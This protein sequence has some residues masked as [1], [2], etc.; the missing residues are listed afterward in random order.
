MSYYWQFYLLFRHKLQMQIV[1][2][3]KLKIPIVCV[4]I[5]SYYELVNSGILDESISFEEF[6]IIQNE[7]RNNEVKEKAKYQKN[8]IQLEHPDDIAGAIYSTLANIP[9]LVRGDI[10]I[11]NG[12]SSFGLTGHA[13]IVVGANEI[14]HITGSNSIPV[15]LIINFS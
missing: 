6:E 15:S 12:T 10:L 11:S 7:D 13:G 2:Q 4:N 9:T 3:I 8:N 14:L 1:F 5:D